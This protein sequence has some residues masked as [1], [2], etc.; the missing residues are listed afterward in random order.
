[1]LHI[2]VVRESNRLYKRTK[3]TDSPGVSLHRSKV[4]RGSYQRVPILFNVTFTWRSASPAAR[5]LCELA[6]RMSQ[7]QRPARAM[8][9]CPTPAGDSLG[10]VQVSE[11][12]RS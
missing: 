1:M 12:A 3:A 9:A 4:G 8:C 10:T 6:R 5:S 7:L 11:A 2:T